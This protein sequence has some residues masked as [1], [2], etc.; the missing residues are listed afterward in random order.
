MLFV[1]QL[2]LRRCGLIKARVQ[3]TVYGKM[4]LLIINYM[5]Y[6]IYMY[7][8]VANKFPS[9]FSKYCSHPDEIED[10]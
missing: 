9:V 1:S 4:Y 6:G 7:E 3:S 2:I 8:L 5:I 10:L